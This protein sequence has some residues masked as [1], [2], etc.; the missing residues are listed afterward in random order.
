M[1]YI[2]EEQNIVCEC[3]KTQLPTCVENIIIPINL[4]DVQIL[5]YILD[6]FNN[7]YIY[8]TYSDQDGYITIDTS[9]FPMGMFNSYSGDFIFYITLLNDPKS[10]R[11]YFRSPN[12]YYP[13][14]RV[15][16][17]E[18]KYV[19]V[20]S[21][22]DYILDMGTFVCCCKETQRTPCE[23]IFLPKCEEVIF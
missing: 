20:Y 15:S 5:V 22:T 18:T 16:V 11:Q 7:E 17:R 12:G 19:N 10:E 21:Y 2:I 14:L 13:C 6:K 9:L 23:N 8:A 4:A 3:L 1:S